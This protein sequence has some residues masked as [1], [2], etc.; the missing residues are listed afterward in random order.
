MAKPSDPR[1]LTRFVEEFTNYSTME[2]D[3]AA[4]A[5]SDKLI[6]SKFV[7][8]Y[9]SMADVLEAVGKQPVLSKLKTAT[10]IVSIEVV[11]GRLILDCLTSGTNGESA[12]RE[13][14]VLP[15]IT[16]V[17]NDTLSWM[18]CRGFGLSSSINMALCA[19]SGDSAPY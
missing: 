14:V 18:L 13:R 11:K 16:D 10:K 2:D 9:T 5:Q 17:V 19:R 12:Q 7:D 15:L 3:P 6:A 1:G 4:A 8:V